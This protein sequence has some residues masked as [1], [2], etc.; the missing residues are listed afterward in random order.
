MIQPASLRLTDLR[1]I[2]PPR[3]RDSHKGDYGHVLVIG[4]NHGM[5]G[6]ARMAAEAAARLGA[7][8]VSIA[9]RAGHAPFLAATRPELMVHGVECAEA[10]QPLLLRATVLVLGPGL[11]LDDWA[12]DLFEMAFAAGLPMVVD[13][14]ALNLLAASPRRPDAPVIFS[15]H[16][17][18]A[19]RLLGIRVADVQA[20]RA[21]SV[22]A[23]RESWGGVWL[24]KGAG[25]L[26]VDENGR[27]ARCEH[28]HPAMASGGMG[29]VLSGMLA[30]LWAQ[31]LAPGDAARLGVCLH[32]A[33]GECAALDGRG[34]LALD[35]LPHA[36]RL[37]EAIA[38][39]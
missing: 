16:P 12:R 8:L 21:A 35:L 37:L 14:D 24:L 39:C 9:T 30:A 26:I 31:G 25:S 15:P 38:P 20:D 10:L 28:G 19:G 7:G 22:R 4:G 18:E 34:V 6:A 29:D 36:R 17:G 11:G 5:A 27:L 32:A 2:L 23:L 3:R 1:G 13:A 33:A